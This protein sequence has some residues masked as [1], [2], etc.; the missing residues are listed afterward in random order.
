MTIS[1]TNLIY[2]IIGVFI[3]FLTT[4]LGAAAVFFF[5]KQLS[6]NLKQIFLG[7]ASGVMISASIFSLIIPALEDQT[8]KNIPNVVVV[9]IGFI[10]GCLFLFLL[11]KIVP[12]IHKNKNDEEEGL[13]TRKLKKTTK[14][15]L[16]VTIHN[17]P[18]GLSV[19]IAFGVAINTN[20][21][22]MFLSALMLAIGIGIQN[23]PEGIAVALPFKEE[24]TTFKSFLYGMLSGL[25]EPISAIIGIVLAYYIE[26]IMP[27]ALAFSAGAM[28]YVTIEEL[29]PESQLNSTNHFGT[30]S[31]IFGFLVMMILDVSLG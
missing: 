1:T 25:V 31:F 13:K 30:F 2:T 14:M 27:Y 3:T 24:T 6:L 16:A 4:T 18:E 19:G 11:D 29:I 23:F 28:I 17:I 26:G 9:V 22:A 8:P 15:L 20:N 21:D 5:R 7:F 10:L 12:H